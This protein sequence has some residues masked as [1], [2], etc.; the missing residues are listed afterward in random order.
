M[1]IKNNDLFSN[2]NGFNSISKSDNHIV[3][4]KSPT[5]IGICDLESYN[6]SQI[7]FE[8][9]NQKNSTNLLETFENISVTE[10]GPFILSANQS[11]K[12][13][14][15]ADNDKGF[16]TIKGSSENLIYPIN[17]SK[18]VKITSKI[19]SFVNIN[20]NYQF[21]III[22]ILLLIIYFSKSKK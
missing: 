13:Y 1:N 15:N 12:L 20:F 2:Y 21:V 5:K 10:S 14:V 19:E 4:L 8:I 18:P 7:E 3:L 6:C 16:F 22:L 17:P 9:S 11:N